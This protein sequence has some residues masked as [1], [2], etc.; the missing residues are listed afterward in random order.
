[1]SA[2]PPDVTSIA[3]LGAGSMGHGIAEVAAL[4]GY[5]VRLRDIDEE[6]VGRGY[7]RLTWSV[8]KLAESG[9]LTDDEATAT[10]ERIEP[11]V[12]L[13]TALDGVDVVI[14]AVPERLDLKKQVFAEVVD[15]APADALFATNT[16]TL[17]ITELAAATDRPA[18]FC[19]MH[20]F[21]P[22]VRMPLVEVVAGEQTS[23]E[24]LA[25]ATALVD[26]F[27]KTPIRVHRDEPGFVVNRVL[28]PLLNEAGWLVEMDAASVAEVDSTAKHDLELPMG[29]FELLDQ[30]GID[31]IVDVLDYMAATL[32]DGYRSC[33]QFTARVEDADFG[34]KS[35]R[36]FYDWED[37]GASIPV[38][39]GRTV[40]RD[41]LVAVAINE[42]AKLVAADVAPP[43]T[44]DEGLVLGAGFP[45]GPTELAAGVGYQRTY[46][47]LAELFAETGLARYEPHEQHEQWANQGG[48]DIPA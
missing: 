21:N 32:G 29:C 13:G 1:M 4:A 35:G 16:S 41:R 38:D 6:T 7:D 44:V 26:S 17:S 48:P 37:G 22:P 33:P 31:V 46:D 3:V 47:T 24:T 9:R 10:L 8:E 14:E 40:V 2:S 28:V 25:R 39:E 36:G 30:I 27:E 12:D 45:V 15:H 5:E 23:E 11:I 19:G 43:E 34:K 42:T 18:D 20:F